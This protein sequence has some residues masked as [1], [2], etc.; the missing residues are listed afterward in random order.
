MDKDHVIT[1]AQPTLVGREPD[2][3]EEDAITPMEGIHRSQLLS[4]QLGTF[5]LN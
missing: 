1:S 4:L 5:C 2:C 3:S